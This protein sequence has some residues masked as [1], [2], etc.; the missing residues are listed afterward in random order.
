MD[1]LIPHVWLRRQKVKGKEEFLT[2][3]S[4]GIR[5]VAALKH[6]FRRAIMTR[7]NFKVKGVF[8]SK[9]GGHVLTP[10][11]DMCQGEY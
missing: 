10:V 1:H 9:I 8:Y 4:H 11:F 5:R 6:P 7:I 2:R 3:R